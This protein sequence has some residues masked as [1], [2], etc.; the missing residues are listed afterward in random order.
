ME[1]WESDYWAREDAIYHYDIDEEIYID[2]IIALMMDV[3]TYD[4]YFVE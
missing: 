1:T 3:E 2:S 4:D